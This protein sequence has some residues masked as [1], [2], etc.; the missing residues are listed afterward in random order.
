MTNDLIEDYIS[1]EWQGLSDTAKKKLK[2]GVN[3][4]LNLLSKKEVIHTC[5]TCNWCYESMNT[6]K[7]EYYCTWHNTA[8]DKS[9]YCAEHT[10][11][12]K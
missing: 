7:K 5:T 4:V 1:D 10:G 9:Y 11:R 6:T 12:N 2:P 8:V 3:W